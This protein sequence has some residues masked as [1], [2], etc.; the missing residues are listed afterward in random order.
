MEFSEVSRLYRINDLIVYGNSG[1]CRVEAVGPL[2]GAG[3]DPKR[4]YY[5]LSPMFSSGIIYTPVDTNVFMRPVLSQNEVEELID[6]LP[7]LEDDAGSVTNLRLLS[8]Y[9]RAALDSHRC[10]ALLKLI[11]TLR[12]RGQESARQ[13]RRLGLTEMKY[14]KLAEELIHGEFSVALGIP[15]EEVPDY[16]SQR[17]SDTEPVSGV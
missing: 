1:V 17:L 5:T 13:G 15:M 3:A 4:P 10:E 7:E 9:C 8:E 6:R 11:K 2:K 16:I 14:R 12:R